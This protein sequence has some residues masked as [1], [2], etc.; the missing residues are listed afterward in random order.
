M[1]GECSRG[2]LRHSVRVSR[3]SLAFDAV[4]G[5]SARGQKTAN[6][7][8]TPSFAAH[9]YAEMVRQLRNFGR[10]PVLEFYE[11]LHGVG[12]LF[13]ADQWV[14]AVGLRDIQEIA[15]RVLSNHWYE[16]AKIA[17]SLAAR[18]NSVVKDVRSV[19]IGAG[20]GR[21]IA[22]ELGHA[23]LYRG[24]RNPFHPDEEA[25]ADY[26]AGRLDAARGTNWQLGEM[27]FRAIGCVGPTCNHPTPAD[28][29][30]AYVT[31]YEEQLR[32]A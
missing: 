22:H 24:W 4:A 9:A 11:T 19:M 28:R 29:S 17:Q 25:G 15:D 10:A 20:I 2:C 3:T 5:R 23:V 27:F 31:G 8:A 7:I 32:A 21:C 14:I 12:G 26:Y 18:Q 1:Y 30:N 13:I 6:R 16:V